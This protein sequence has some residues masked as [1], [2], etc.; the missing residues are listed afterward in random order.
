MLHEVMH[1]D[2]QEQYLQAMKIEVASLL[3][4]RTRN[5]TPRSKASRVFKSTWV[6]KLKRLP[7]GIPSKLKARFF[8]RGDI[9]QEG[10]DVF[11]TYEINP[12][13]EVFEDNMA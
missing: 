13:S 3:Q 10:V 11:E 6:S 5:S 12:Q 2:H 1:G 7:D 4:Q 8:V 9:Q